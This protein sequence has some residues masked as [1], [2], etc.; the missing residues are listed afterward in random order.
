MWFFIILFALSLILIFSS[1][2][3][4][5]K[6]SFPFRIPE[7]LQKEYKLLNSDKKYIESNIPYYKY[8]I[9]NLFIMK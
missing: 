5:R 8:D 3:K 2:R 1:K 9:P 6:N 7:N 4:P